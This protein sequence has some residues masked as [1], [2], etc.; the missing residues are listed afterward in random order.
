MSDEPIENLSEI[1][2]VINKANTVPSEI[3][4]VFI[5]QNC[6]VEEAKDLLNVILKVLDEGTQK[7]PERENELIKENLFK[8]Q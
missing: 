4:Q 6:T 2:D 1:A 8:S 5:K 7:Y 3:L